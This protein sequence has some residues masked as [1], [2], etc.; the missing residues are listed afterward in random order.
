MPVFFRELAKGFDQPFAAGPDRQQR[1][2]RSRLL[3]ETDS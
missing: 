1:A 2:R 3:R